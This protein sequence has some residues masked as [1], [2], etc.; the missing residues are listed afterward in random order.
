MIKENILCSDCNNNNCFIK[1]FCLNLPLPT[2]IIINE[3]KMIN[4]YK[5][6]QRIFLEG[7]FVDRTYFIQSG[8]V[9]VYKDGA[10][11]KNQTIRLS[12]NGEILGHRGLPN[13]QKQYPISADVISD[14]AIICFFEKSFFINL[15][16]Q[17]H[18]LAINLMFLFANELNTEESKLR[19]LS[20]FNVREKVA[21]ALQIIIEAFGLNKKNEINYIENLSR[22]DIAELVGLNS[23]QVIKVLSDFKEDGIIECHKKSI[24][25]LN[26]KKFKEIISI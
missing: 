18:K 2:T 15:I 4:Y 12:T 24:R 1:K 23:N 25:I 16:E 14:S 11:N 13:N 6:K 20:I 5:K 17:S 21:K 8:I 10:F 3:K 7:N 26:L 19:D 22:Q 9:K